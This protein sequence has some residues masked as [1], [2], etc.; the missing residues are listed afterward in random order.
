[1]KQRR[2]REA[3]PD[4]VLY[5]LHGRENTFTYISVPNIDVIFNPKCQR[6]GQHSTGSN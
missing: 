2:I 5:K 6:F 4:L 1:M 3:T